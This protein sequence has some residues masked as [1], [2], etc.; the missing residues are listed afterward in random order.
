LMRASLSAKATCFEVGS[1]SMS[2]T[3][4]SWA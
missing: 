2:E 4:F 1:L 3:G